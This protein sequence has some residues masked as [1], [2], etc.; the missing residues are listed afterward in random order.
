WLLQ[1]QEPNRSVRLLGEVLELLQRRGG[2]A[3]DPALVTREALRPHVD[4]D[5]RTRA[6][7]PEHVR[8]DLDSDAH[9]SSPPQISVIWAVDGTAG[10][11]Q[12]VMPFASH[13]AWRSVALYAQPGSAQAALTPAHR[14]HPEVPA[15]PR[16]R[17]STPT[18]AA[19][20][21]QR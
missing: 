12:G 16:T 14:R 7:P 4:V 5:P 10:V 8:L 17:P 11:P 20:P 3:G 6:C 19:R 13:V 2:I 21:T 15:A 18:V 1:E 9:A